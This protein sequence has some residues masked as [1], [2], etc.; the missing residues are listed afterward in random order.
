[1]SHILVAEMFHSNTPFFFFFFFFLRFSV[2]AFSA[3]YVVG[4]V[5]T[6]REKGDACL[7]PKWIGWPLS[8]WLSSGVTGEEQETLTWKKRGCSFSISLFINVPTASLLTSST[9]DSSTPCL[10]FI[11]TNT[12]THT[13]LTSSLL[14]RYSFF[15]CW[16]FFCSFTAETRIGSAASPLTCTRPLHTHTHTTNSFTPSARFSAD[17]VLMFT[18]CRGGNTLTPR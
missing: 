6:V 2:R 8:S 4:L 15:F 9:H 12:P 18:P 10:L 1:M 5:E 7:P 16:F 3:G 13:L 14:R 11:H 17:D